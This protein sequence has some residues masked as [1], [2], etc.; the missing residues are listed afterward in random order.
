MSNLNGSTPSRIGF[1]GGSF[2][3]IHN[4]H[5]FIIEKSIQDFE[6]DLLFLCPAYQAPLREQKPIFNPVQRLEMARLVAHSNQ[7]MEVLDFEI[8]QPK[9]SF[10]YE[11]IQEVKKS[12]PK[13]KIFLAIGLDQFEKLSTWRWIRELSK[14]VHFIVFARGQTNTPAPAI[15]DIQYT[16]MQNPLIDIS[17]TQIRKCLQNGESV[18]H[19]IPDV[20]LSYLEKNNLLRQKDTS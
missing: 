2:D 12:Y 7:K 5:L 20:I 13:S 8:N 1:F 9:T 19:W 14:E 11:T 10:T 18:A 17:S 16:F 3:P 15:S 4:G 6:L